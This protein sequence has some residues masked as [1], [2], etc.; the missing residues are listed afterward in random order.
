S[1]IHQEGYCVMRG[2]CGS[3]QPFGKQ[4]NCPYNKPAEEP[5]E[6]LRL[7]LVEICGSQFEN[8]LVCCDADQLDDLRESTKQAETLVSACPACWKN[9]LGFFCT[10][11][12]S[13]NQSTFVNVT[14]IGNSV[15]N[16]EIVSSVDFFVGENYGKGF[17][18]SC[19]DIKFAA[20][21]GYVMDFIG[22]G[23]TNYHD[24][25]IYL[26]MERPMI[27]SP[28]QINFP[29][30][31]PLKVMTP[32]DEPAIRCNDTDVNYRCSCMDCQYVCPILDPTPEENPPCRV[33]SINCWSF[34]L[35]LCYII[36]IL[37]VFAVCCV[38][39]PNYDAIWYERVP[40]SSIEARVPD[41]PPSSKRYW[42]NQLLQEYFYQQGFICARHPW[43]TIILAGI[44]VLLASSGWAC[45]S[46]ETDPVRLWVAPN[47]DSALHKEYFDQKFGPFYR[48]Q[49]I[50]ITNK[51]ESQSIVTYENL[52]KLFIIEKQIREFKSTPH[53]YT[54]QDLC[55]HP[56]GDTCIVQSVTGYWQSNIDNFKE[57][58][59]E[60][61]FGTCTSAPS[62]C[63]PDF[64]QPLKPDM[65]LGGFEN[66]N[67]K[68]AK[69]LV[70]TFVLNNYLEKDKV[71]MAEE[72]E[73][74]LRKYLHK[75]IE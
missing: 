51:N 55:F 49:Q 21:N 32:F 64:Q 25:L 70:L 7:K 35:Y 26:G 75:V 44:F 42:L 41:T 28:F 59:W 16:D 66:S 18:D 46:V 23:A 14:S 31:D 12:C 62:F 54:L 72:W 53:N 45:F 73:E 47:S 69:A 57:E 5:D 19:K 63:L 50:F 29:L 36:L 24:M 68:Q 11:T 40:L 71:K 61:D 33:G 1:D 58:T 27:G 2:Q 34:S 48:T 30:T 67:Y 65:I 15:T 38:I 22:G 4:L 37:G 56:N 60:D 3:K 13:P 9:F 39:D 17:Y 43:Y 74:K 10:F 52:R 6:D 8:S 20:T